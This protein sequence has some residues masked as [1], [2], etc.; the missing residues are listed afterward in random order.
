MMTILQP[1][2]LPSLGH[3]YVDEDEAV[4]LVDVGE[5][6]GDAHNLLTPHRQIFPLPHVITIMVMAIS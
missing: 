3:P 5:L 1:S 4:A 2:I 6:V